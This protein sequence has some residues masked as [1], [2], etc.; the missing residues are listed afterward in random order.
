MDYRA[1]NELSESSGW[2]IPN[3]KQLLNNIGQHQPKYFAVLDLTSGYYQAP[4]AQDSRDLI[5]FITHMG[6]YEWT[7]VPMGA[8][9]APPY[10]QY[11]MVNTVFT[12]LI[13]TICEVYLDGIIIWGD[14]INQLSTRLEQILQRAENLI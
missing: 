4:L 11:Q 6:M 3:I 2:P 10:F 12:G 13:H 8:K 5:A 1:L 7:R 14:S 9:G